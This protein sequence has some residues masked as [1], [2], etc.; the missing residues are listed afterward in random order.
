MRI[1]NERIAVDDQRIAVG[2]RAHRGFI[3]DRGATA[4]PVLDDDVRPI[5]FA[6]LLAQETRQDVGAAARRERNEDPDR[7]RALRPTT[8]AGH[9][10]ERSGE[11]ER[12]GCDAQVEET[13]TA[14]GHRALLSVCAHRLAAYCLRAIVHSTCSLEALP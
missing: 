6:D 12:E 14:I 3:G 8:V 11:S 10:Q 2:R 5:D 9:R 13:A 1:D 7:T 4:W